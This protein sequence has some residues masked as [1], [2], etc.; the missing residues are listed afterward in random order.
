M[1][2][3]YSAITLRPNSEEDKEK[4]S[5]FRN[6]DVADMFTLFTFGSG[7]LWLIMCAICLYDPTKLEPS[8]LGIE[9]ATVCLALAVWLIRKR[10]KS[11]LATIVLVS[12]GVA[13]L[14]HVFELERLQVKD[15]HAVTIEIKKVMY[16]S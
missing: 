8:D 1:S 10:A 4:F 11:T 12:Y 14:L 5:G 2:A 7:A 9:L 6:D 16:R 15:S 3:D 13:C